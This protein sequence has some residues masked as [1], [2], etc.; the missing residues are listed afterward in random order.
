MCIYVV[1]T[2]CTH[3]IIIIFI[4]Q[5]NT[6]HLYVKNWKIQNPSKV[7]HMHAPHYFNLLSACVHGEENTPYKSSQL[8]PCMVF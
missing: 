4:S 5:G 2:V 6:K 3:L 7:S 8:V 1:I